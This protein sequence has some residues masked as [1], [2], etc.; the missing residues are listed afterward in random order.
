MQLGAFRYTTHHGSGP[1][2]R[3]ARPG[4]H[5]RQGLGRHRR[6]PE[7]SPRGAGGAGAEP[8]RGS[9]PEEADS[10]PAGRLSWRAMKRRVSRSVIV[11]AALVVGVV[12]TLAA[13]HWNTVRDH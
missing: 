3:R 11:A 10:R 2:A 5:G 6:T 13:L 9:G 7:P 4:A 1:M 8:W 12:A